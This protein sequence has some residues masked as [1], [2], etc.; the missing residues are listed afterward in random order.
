MSFGQVN[1]EYSLHEKMCLFVLGLMQRDYPDIVTAV[2]T[3]QAVQTVLNTAS[4]TLRFMI[5]GGIVDKN[6]GNE[7]N[8][9]FL[10]IQAHTVYH[11]FH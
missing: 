4:E 11:H 7:L 6:E 8:K 5:R 3:K 9:V 10:K 2:K 1:T